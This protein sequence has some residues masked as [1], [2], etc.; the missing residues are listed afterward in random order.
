MGAAM[1]RVAGVLLAGASLG[2]GAEIIITAPTPA[3][4]ARQQRGMPSVL[5][6]PVPLKQTSYLS[7]RARAWRIGNEGRVWVARDLVLVP[8]PATSDP[9]AAE[10]QRTMQWNLM[11]AQSYRGH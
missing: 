2:A 11:R 1:R 4:A 8:T 5:V 9:D 6:A 3:E 10:R 7:A